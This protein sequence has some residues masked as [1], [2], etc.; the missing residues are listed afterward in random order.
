MK[1][2]AELNVDMN[3]GIK[4][5]DPITDAEIM[6]WRKTVIKIR[7][8]TYFYLIFEVQILAKNTDSVDFR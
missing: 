7:S 1:K 5:K 3:F 4:L 8:K 6:G 2:Q